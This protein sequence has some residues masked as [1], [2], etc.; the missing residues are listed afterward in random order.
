MEDS[1]GL[2]VSDL[3]ALH[4]NSRSDITPVSPPTGRRAAV[5]PPTGRRAAPDPQPTGRR[6]KPEPADPQP[7]GRRAKIDPPSLPPTGRRATDPQPTGRRAK[8][9]PTDP[10]PT[11]RR[12]KVESPDPQPTGR[13]AKID[14]PSLPPVAEGSGGRRRAPE[15][16]EPPE[17]P[18][19]TRT[20]T[21][22]AARAAQ[23]AAQ[24]AVPAVPVG[25]GSSPPYRI[26]PQGNGRTRTGNDMA[27]APEPPASSAPAPAPTRTSHRAAVEPPPSNEHRIAGRRTATETRAP[28][29]PARGTASRTDAP[30]VAGAPKINGQAR[31]NGAPRAIAMTEPVSASALAAAA[32]EVATTGLNA[33]SRSDLPKQTGPRDKPRV[34]GSPSQNGRVRPPRQADQALAS[35]PGTATPPSAA[36][37]APGAKQ[38][39]RLRPPASPPGATT[40]RRPAGTPRPNGAPGPNGG[41]GPNGLNGAPGPNGAPGHKG[42]PGP[43]DAPSQPRMPGPMDA[44]SQT[45]MPSQNDAPSQTRMPRPNGAPGQGGPGQGG[46]GQGGPGGAPSQNRMPKPNGPQSN[47]PRPNGADAGGDSRRIPVGGRPAQRPQQGPPPGPPIPNRLSP[48]VDASD[49]YDHDFDDAPLDDDAA[50]PLAAESPVARRTRPRKPGEPERREDIDPASLTAEME[51][52]SEMVVQKRKVDATLA[53]FSAVHDEMVAEEEERRTRRKRLM[54][55]LAK[56]DDLEEAL[57]SKNVATPT[58]LARPVSRPEDDEDEEEGPAAYPKG[59]SGAEAADGFDE[60]ADRHDADDRH[61]ADDVHHADAFR[62]ADGFH[63]AGGSPSGTGFADESG[64]PEA[65]GYD[66]ADADGDHESDGLPPTDEPPAGT[67]EPAAR[68]PRDKR[69]SWGLKGLAIAA[70]VAVL[71]LTG[72]EWSTQTTDNNQIQ[73]VAAL[74]ENSPAIANGAKQ[75]GDENFLFVGTNA[76]AGVSSSGIVTDTVMVA[77]IPADRSRVEIVSF[78]GNLQVTRPPC[79]SW[80]NATS[81]YSSTTEPAQ[82]GVRLDAIY[83]IGGPR[84]VTDTVQELSGL[85]V[86]H[87]VGMDTQGFTDLAG[88]LPQVSLCTKGSVVDDKLGTIIPRAGQTT[89]TPQQALNFVRADHVQGD[90]PGEYGKIARQ[91]RFLAAV[92]RQVIGQ[93]VLTSPS[94]LN[95]LLGVFSR[96]TFG[97]NMDV[98]ALITLAQSLQGV[99]LNQITFITLP[100]T[101]SDNAQGEATPLTDES[102]QLFN[103]IIGNAPLPGTTPASQDSNS[104]L[105]P[106]GIKIQVLN[107]GDAQGGAASQASQKLK[108]QGFSVVNGGNSHNVD[109]TVIKYAAGDQAKAQLL[110][111]AVPKAVL[112]EDPS[113]NGAIELILGP[114]FDGNIVTAKSGGATTNP[115]TPSPTALT[116]LS[117]ADTSCA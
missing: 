79:A 69:I 58:M 81:S 70:A 64:F 56:D 91:Q 85:R 12:A 90:A 10:Q 76:R 26:Q 9:E 92:L 88:A 97:A 8:V 95:A 52:I 108:Q 40:G 31:S 44:P 61:Q 63:P 18:T 16:A 83:A 21:R 42:G 102:T 75:S 78:P 23:Q 93:S 103:A 68:S 99:N 111:S 46:P 27:A 51:P 29:A 59:G 48:D 41:P 30:R 116:T 112:Q 43:N 94:K 13:R 106:Q 20:Q 37:G 15:P 39:R 109:Q 105:T 72:I 45:R 5:D 34:A 98:S 24:A 14:P 22:A 74:D 117:A 67:A 19:R 62:P 32:A 3:V 25:G 86:N 36:P 104:P 73:T 6:A 33:P 89:L 100:T 35:D 2:S 49:G 96:S 50:A 53:R 82:D 114:N 7:T 87:F 77:H 66:A 115:G 4:G 80:N 55:W 1:G 107:G 84:C 57:S 101:G 60:L 110:G 113:A 17:E 28:S 54:P 11:G 38:N 71:A 47:G 65:D